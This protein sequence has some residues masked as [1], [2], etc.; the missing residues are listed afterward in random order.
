MASLQRI[1]ITTPGT[2]ND[3]KSVC[4]LAVGGLDAAQS[5]QNFIAATQGGNQAAS[6]A[7]KVGAV[8][9]AGTLTVATG[10]SANDQACTILNV[11]L[12]GKTSSTANNE[13]TVSATAATQAANMTAAIN[14]STS[15]A[16]KVTASRV[17][18][19][20]TITSVVPGLLGNGLQLS[21]GNL[22][23]VTAGAFAGG[24]DGTAY[25]IDLD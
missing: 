3:F 2:A 4:P 15:L 17:G 7:I 16:G 12:T 9:A 20:V 23:N 8:Q 19:V 11:T 13:F 6:Y 1:V 10:G 24:T 25:T 22:A 5:L 18:A 21:A 14:A